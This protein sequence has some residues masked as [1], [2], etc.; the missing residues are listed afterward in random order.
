MIDIQTRSE[1]KNGNPDAFRKVFR[2]LYPRLKGYC[3][4]FI[5]EEYVVEDIIQET[6]ISLWEK[7]GTIDILKTIESLI[8]V[9]VRNRCFNYL[10]TKQLELGRISVDDL[11]TPELQYLYQLDLTG[12]E[13][14]SMEEMLIMSL[15][16]EV[17]KLPSK[18]KAVFIK[19]K[20]EGRKQKEVAEELGISLKMVEKHISGAKYRIKEK[21]LKQYPILVVLVLM[22][23]E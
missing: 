7:R 10:K 14:K 23:M 3:K 12:K 21:L 17:E 6:F 16:Q 4:L 2:L 13:E 18:M 19:C 1:I 15:Q 11:R 5:F 9:M 20:I 8:F 22:L